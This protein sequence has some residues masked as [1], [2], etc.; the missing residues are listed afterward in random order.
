MG[1]DRQ[2]DDNS[3]DTFSLEF[4]SFFVSSHDFGFYFYVEVENSE[5]KRKFEQPA[6][7]K[8]NMSFIELNPE[9]KFFRAS[10]KQ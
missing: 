7:W 1:K 10:I 3:D 8:P 4:C 2:T 5:K 9:F 6:I